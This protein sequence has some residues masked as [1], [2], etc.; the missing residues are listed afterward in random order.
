ML[1]LT[2]GLQ[3]VS[4]ATPASNQSHVVLL[5]QQDVCELYHHFVPR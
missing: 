1:K 5:G 4:D 3:V 2:N